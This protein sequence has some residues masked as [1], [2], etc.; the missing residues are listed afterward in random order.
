MDFMCIIIDVVEINIY[1]NRHK[2]LPSN[3]TVFDKRNTTF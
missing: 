3:I 2:F 1:E